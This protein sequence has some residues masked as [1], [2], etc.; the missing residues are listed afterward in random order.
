MA[1]R[2][3]SGTKS[4]FWHERIKFLKENV[5]QQQVIDI[6][7]YV[8]YT[9]N[10]FLEY[11]YAINNSRDLSDDDIFTE[12]NNYFSAWS[13]ILG[14]AWD[15]KVDECLFKSK[16]QS[17]VLLKRFKQVHEKATKIHGD[18]IISEEIFRKVLSPIEN[19]PFSHDKI[20]E[21][22][23]TGLPEEN[24]KHLDAWVK[25]AIDFGKV[26]TREE[27]LDTNIRGEPGAGILS[28][29]IDSESWHQTFPDGD[30]GLDPSDGETRY[31]TVKRPK[32]CGYTCRPEIWHNGGKLNTNITVK[33]KMVEDEEN[34]PIRNSYPL[35]DLDENVKLRIVWSTISGSEFKEIDLR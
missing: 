33:A 13:H 35:P 12:I 9:F 28:Q 19:I 23:S 34:I 27:I 26:H 20:I 29:P 14:E 11:P 24:W 2:L 17:R 25:D 10:W 4:Q 30:K 21:A 7:K 22:Y 1:A 8:E 5:K 3:V 16:T 6:E 18:G 32:N 15:S 31:L